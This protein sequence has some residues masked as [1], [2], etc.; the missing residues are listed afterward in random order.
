MGLYRQLEVPFRF[1]LE[2]NVGKFNPLFWSSF[3]IRDRHAGEICFIP[4]AIKKFFR[5]TEFKKLKKKFNKKFIKFRQIDVN[6]SELCNKKESTK[7]K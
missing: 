4:N 3:K 6:I 7:F 1:C 5:E 2:S